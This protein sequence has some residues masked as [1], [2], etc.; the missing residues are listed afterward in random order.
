MRGSLREILLE[1]RNGKRQTSKEIRFPGEGRPGS[2]HGQAG[3][4]VQD[5]REIPLEIGN[6]KLQIIKEIRILG[7][8][9]ADPACV[10]RPG[11][12]GGGTGRGP[13]VHREN[14][15]GNKQWNA[16]NQ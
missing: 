16:S 4:S 2:L 9:A 12:V 15:S 11:G 5:L 14:Y 1:I 6:E 10:D 3:A 8:G 13:A 7:E